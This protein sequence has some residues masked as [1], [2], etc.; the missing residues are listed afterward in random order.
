MQMGAPGGGAIKIAGLDLLNPTGG[1]IGA[2]EWNIIIGADTIG[3][4]FCGFNNYYWYVRLTPAAA[5]QTMVFETNPVSMSGTV[6]G[7]TAL[8]LSQ[9]IG[10]V[11]QFGFHWGTDPNSTNYL[12][13][14]VAG[15]N[16]NTRLFGPFYQLE[17]SI[18]RTVGVVE[19]TITDMELWAWS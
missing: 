2:A 13:A 3:L 10:V 15:G 16:M 8:F 9:A 17:M 19:T 1:T 5:A 6:S 18:Q 11:T 7:L 14:G 12:V 4:D